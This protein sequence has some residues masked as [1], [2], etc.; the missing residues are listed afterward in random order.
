MTPLFADDSAPVLAQT[1]REPRPK[2][3]VARG[4]DTRREGEAPG[5]LAEPTRTLAN[6]AH[7]RRPQ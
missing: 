1:L 5:D 3:T 6:L 7:P 2:R 4:R